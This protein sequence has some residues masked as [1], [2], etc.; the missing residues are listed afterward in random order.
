MQ[1]ALL[2]DNNT[3]L[4][5]KNLDLWEGLTDVASTH[6]LNVAD[7]HQNFGFA[8]LAKEACFDDDA[9][10]NG[11]NAEINGDEASGV[12]AASTARSST[13]YRTRWGKWASDASAAKPESTSSQKFQK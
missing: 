4:R 3:E 5:Q 6:H 11:N 1:Q 13:D 12:A 8:D 10:G 9:D 2:A 7:N